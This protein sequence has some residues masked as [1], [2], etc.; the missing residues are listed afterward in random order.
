MSAD[1]IA[2]AMLVLPDRVIRG[3]VT[4]EG[5]QIVAL[6]EG[7]RVLPGALDWAGDYLAPGLVELHTDNLEHHLQPRPGVK[8]PQDQAIIAHDAVLAGCGITTV[9]DA[10]RLGAI[11]GLTYSWSYARA[12]ADRISHLG[13]ADML[14]I[15]HFLHLRA[16]ICSETLAEEL[17]Q[18]TPADPVRLISI[19]D[20]TPGQRQFRDPRQ[21][22]PYFTGPGGVD[23]VALQDHV[24]QLLRVRADHGDDHEAAIIATAARLGAVLASHDDTTAEEV[25]QSA[26]HD[27]RIAEFPTT[28]V[29]A[30]ACHAH[31]IKVMAGAPN[32]IRG[33]SHSGN[34]AASD[35]ARA[36]MLDILSSDYVPASLLSGAMALADI[37]DDLPRAI[38]TVTA[39]PAEAAGLK[40]RGRIAP[41]LRADLIRFAG[42]DGLAVLRETWVAGRRVA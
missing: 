26:A 5:G 34:I 7:D 33:G 14:R 30:A 31:G 36:G 12:V 25:V 17:A 19:M 15:A 39:N 13:A 23:E 29:A 3:S 10:L 28:E 18:F 1:V 21:F 35:L 11:E 8:W 4:L 9:F 38:A 42:K 24:D 16:E 32:L 41:G 2:N 27:V 6:T 20:H 40:D 37:W 22:A